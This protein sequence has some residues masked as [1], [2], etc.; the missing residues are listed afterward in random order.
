MLRDPS[1]TPVS[2]S[3]RCFLYDA[4]LAVD[5]E[6]YAPEILADIE[7]IYLPMTKMGIGTVWETEDGESAFGGAGSLCHGWSA[8]PIYYYHIIKGR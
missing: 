2:L 7:K 3:M 4:L 5:F 6:A 8:M 1:M